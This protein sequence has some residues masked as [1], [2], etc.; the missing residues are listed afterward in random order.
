MEFE[1]LLGENTGHFIAMLAST[2]VKSA[3]SC[4]DVYEVSVNF[5]DAQH[6]GDRRKKSQQCPLSRN[7]RSKT[8][9][10]AGRGF[11][12][13]GRSK[14]SNAFIGLNLSI[15]LSMSVQTLGLAAMVGVSG[16]QHP[17]ARSKALLGSICSIERSRVN[18]LQNPEPEKPL[19]PHWRVSCH[20]M[21]HI[22]V[23]WDRLPKQFSQ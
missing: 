17:W 10:S 16:N 4:M 22:L 8:F 19:A 9:F 13:L 15:G 14:L 6:G 7:G 1:P 23:G 11:G 18:E 3:L 20:R 21:K 5:N 12:N 2:Q